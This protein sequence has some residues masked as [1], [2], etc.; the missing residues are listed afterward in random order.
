MRAPLSFQERRKHLDEL[1]PA[2]PGAFAQGHDRASRASKPSLHHVVA[3]LYCCATV[4]RFAT[5]GTRRQMASANTVLL[6]HV[7]L[8]NAGS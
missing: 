7:L 2:R 6:D 3:V 5:K 4:S 8:V 1:R